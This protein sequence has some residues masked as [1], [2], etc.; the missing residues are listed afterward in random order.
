MSV[1]PVLFDNPMFLS[2]SHDMPSQPPLAIVPVIS[3]TNFVNA[4][5]GRSS[6][7]RGRGR[8]GNN[9]E[10]QLTRSNSIGLQVFY[11]DSKKDTMNDSDSSELSDDLNEDVADMIPEPNDSLI[12]ES[13]L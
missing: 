7:G 1:S 11:G 2:P 9:K 5:Q 6:R 10:Y 3:P 8:G 4:T 12:N 13:V